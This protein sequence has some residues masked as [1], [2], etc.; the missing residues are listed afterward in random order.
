MTQ[1]VTP[2]PAVRWWGIRPTTVVLALIALLTLSLLV[3]Q[4]RLAVRAFDETPSSA[5]CVKMVARHVFVLH[6]VGS[7]RELQAPKVVTAWLD[8]F[9]GGTNGGCLI[10]RRQ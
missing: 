4:P 1:Q 8:V 9:N 10:H 3:L 2:S 6:P 7:G 5:P